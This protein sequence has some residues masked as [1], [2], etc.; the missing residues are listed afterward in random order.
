MA[1]L[2]FLRNA[3]IIILVISFLAVVLVANAMTCLHT[4][5]RLLH[6]RTASCITG[7]FGGIHWKSLLKDCLR[8]G[9]H[10][11]S[12]HR[13][14]I[15]RSIRGITALLGCHRSGDKQ[16]QPG[17]R[18]SARRGSGRLRG[19]GHFRGIWG[20]EAHCAGSRTE[21]GTIVLIHP[22]TS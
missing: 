13:R 7:N 5:C 10:A 19:F 3:A 16:R 2:V 18:A 20:R 11:R 6:L 8:V 21:K 4:G 1:R 15:L 9:P 14:S 22:S 12:R 17:R